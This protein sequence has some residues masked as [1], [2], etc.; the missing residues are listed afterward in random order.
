MESETRDKLGLGYRGRLRKSLDEAAYGDAAQLVDTVAKQFLMMQRALRR[1]IAGLSAPTL[2]EFSAAQQEIVAR[3]KQA[4]GEANAPAARAAYEQLEEHHK[5]LHDMVMHWFAELL[6]VATETYGEEG[7]ERMLRKSGEEFK[8]DF[9]KWA[10]MSPEEL[11]SASAWL[12]LSHPHGW[13]RIEEDN[14][15]YTLHQG[16][17]TGGRMIAEGHFDGPGSYKRSQRATDYSVGKAG[18]P[19]YCLHCTMWNTLQ[20]TE[21]FERTPWGIEHP[22]DDSCTI[23]VYK[24]QNQV[25]DEYLNRLRKSK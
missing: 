2:D 8:P 3:F 18:M 23:H 10:S 20:S 15:K 16:C 12:Q 24:E 25:P 13:M 5:K 22:L 21:W 7:L 11:V 17:G 6:S 9:S 19:T 4:T 1:I 14:E